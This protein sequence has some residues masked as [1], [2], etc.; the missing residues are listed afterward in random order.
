MSWQVIIHPKVED[1]LIALPEEDYLRTMVALEILE[2]LGPGLGR[3]F[4]D[5]LKGSKFK[6]LKELRP[7]GNFL[8]L[9]FIFDP[10]RK[11]IVLAAGNKKNQWSH[12]YRTQI[13]I[14]E[15]RYEDYLAEMRNYE[16]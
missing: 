7:R 6:N 9:I 13:E 12:W 15:K 10:E 16:G 11:A 2:E 5:T 4:V 8:R 14:A 3:P 1:W